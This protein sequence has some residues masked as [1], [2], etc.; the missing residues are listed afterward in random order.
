VSSWLILSQA[1]KERRKEMENSET[2]ER[3]DS[4]EISRNA[5]GEYSIKVKAYA[6][7][8]SVEYCMKAYAET[9]EDAVSAAAK[10]LSMARQ[11]V[12]ALGS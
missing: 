4:C 11:E 6:E 8:I 10:A 12:E 3:A 5:K 1:E 7:T 2:V 9:I